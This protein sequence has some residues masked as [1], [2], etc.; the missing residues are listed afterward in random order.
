MQGREMRYKRLEVKDKLREVRGE[1]QNGEARIKRWQV[2][3]ERGE[4]GSACKK[5][6]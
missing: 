1:S 6:S 2:R 4:A 5:E 3:G